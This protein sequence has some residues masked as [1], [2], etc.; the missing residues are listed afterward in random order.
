MLIL[1]FVGL[2][3]V[4]LGLMYACVIDR[5]TSDISYLPLPCRSL[6]FLSPQ[7]RSSVIWAFMS[8]PT[9]RCER[10]SS[11]RYRRDMI[12]QNMF[13]EI[14]DPKHPLHYLLPPVT[15]SQSQIVLWP[16]YPHQLP[17]TKTTRYGRDFIP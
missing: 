5:Q 15:V 12:T 10:T 3:V 13:R 2:S 14:K 16:A 9:C 4:D 11:E 8:T 1:V 7:R 6:A 17:I